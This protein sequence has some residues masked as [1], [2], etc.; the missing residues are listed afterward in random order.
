MVKLMRAAVFEGNGKLIVQK[1]PQPT[2]TDTNF[3]KGNGGVLLIKKENL[4]LL[5]VLKAGICGTDIRILSVPTSYPIPKGTII[6]H[7]FMGEIVEIGAQVKRVCV[8]DHVVVDEHIY[9]GDC[10]YC[11]QGLLNRCEQTASMGMSTNGGFAE[12]AV[13]SERQLYKVPQDLDLHKAV[14]FEP[15]YGTVHAINKV[16][17]R[18]NTTVVIWGGGPIGCCFVELCRI[19]NA[20][21]I[22]VSEPESFRRKYAKQLGAT[23]VIDPN[24]EDLMRIINT[25]APHGVDILI[26]AC[27]NPKVIQNSVEL[28]RA[29]GEI[30]LFG[31]QDDKSEIKF[32][33]AY[34]N[35]RELRFYGAS[36]ASPFVADR[37]VE[38]LLRK[39]FR[40]HKIVTH[41]FSLDEVS[42]G[43]EL[44]KKRKAL[45][46][47]IDPWKNI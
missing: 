34:S 20:K 12:Y 16:E 4:V 23:R 39:D 46:V 17:L 24:S 18:P 38:Y 8:G 10:W 40:L 1:V 44:M 47:V 30:L 42:K 15:L 5:K 13:V 36:A 37:T 11:R 6:G 9:C 2:L 45:K 27:G 25:I 22:I 32:S 31:E 21:H 19:G 26:D 14:L 3:T 28:A 29:Y 35:R 41:E 43:V 33:F 7:E